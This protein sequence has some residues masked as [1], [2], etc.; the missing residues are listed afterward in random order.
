MKSKL[1]ADQR[2][3]LVDEVSTLSDEELG[4]L[5]DEELDMITSE[6]QIHN[7]TSFDPIAAMGVAAAD[8]LTLGL[9]DEVEATAKTAVNAVKGL[10]KDVIS[11]FSSAEEGLPGEG[12]E[13]EAPTNAYSISQDYDRQLEV[14]HDRNDKYAE[15]YPT[16][17][18]I[19]TLGGAVVGLA[20]PGVGAAKLAKGA[21]IAAK[22]GIAAGVGATTGAINAVGHSRDKL[23]NETFKQVLME[24]SIG[25][26]LGGTLGTVGGVLAKRSAAKVASSLSPETNLVAKKFLQK[27]ADTPEIKEYLSGIGKES[28]EFISSILNKTVDGEPL[29]K[30]ND[31]VKNISYKTKK[32]L[33]M[34]HEYTN[35]V[36]N[37]IPGDLS[38]VE[39]R[40]IFSNMKRDVTNK[41]GKYP[42]VMDKKYANDTLAEIANM[43]DQ[44]INIPANTNLQNKVSDP[45]KVSLQDVVAS[46]RSFQGTAWNPETEYSGGT[47]SLMKNASASFNRSIDDIV[48]KVANPTAAREYINSRKA[49]SMLMKFNESAQEAASALKDPATDAMRWGIKDIAKAAKTASGVVSGNPKKIIGAVIGLMSYKAKSADMD[50]ETAMASTR[51]T[52]VMKND[53]AKAS[54]LSE[55]LLN[56]SQIST[57]EFKIA[58]HGENAKILLGE[59]PIERTTMDV[60]NKKTSI[61]KAITQVDRDAATALTR[62]LDEGDDETIGMIM[63]G[64][65]KQPGMGTYFKGGIGFN[66]KVY[67]PEDKQQLVKELES[68]SI[69]HVQRLKLK[70]DLINNNIVP[71][72]QAQPTPV[73]EFIK[74]K[75]NNY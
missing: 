14:I 17:T 72:G 6:T 34:Q 57:E 15:N 48:K 31:T 44:L 37:T 46:K 23:S 63:E 65:S 36:L 56:A 12:I 42:S 50:Q 58:I 70:K 22:A 47:I 45:L 69:D 75:G 3:A 30:A 19:G 7:F 62:A 49:E 13:E 74:R 26:A 53:P 28:D 71:V 33:D 41:L 73:K 18:T 20:I 60:I 38:E 11:T 52:S 61:L 39:A 54:K 67:N 66:G 5:S 9:A 29:L 43:E 64:V 21:S 8:A 32:A 4:Q 40:N 68:M 51:I 27:H 25:A 24:G 55:T 59:N 16:E 35:E 10:A 1:N 2:K